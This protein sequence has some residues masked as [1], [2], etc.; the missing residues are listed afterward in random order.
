MVRKG[1]DFQQNINRCKERNEEHRKPPN[2]LGGGERA[3]RR[4]A[5]RAKYEVSDDIYHRR[6]DDLVEGILDEAAKPAPEEPF[7]FGD[8]KKRNEYRS[9][10]HANRSG[11]EAVGDDHD[12]YG[13]GRCKQ[14]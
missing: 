3:C 5:K 12:R 7:H 2:K 13:L 6:S 10:Q 14:D 1:R 4:E 8:D 11:D 9:Y